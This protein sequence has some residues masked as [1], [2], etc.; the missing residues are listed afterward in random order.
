MSNSYDLLKKELYLL[1]E[2]NQNMI[3]EIAELKQMLMMV[4]EQSAQTRNAI[5][6]MTEKLHGKYT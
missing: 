6:A 3:R 5:N 4:V 2:S 1:K